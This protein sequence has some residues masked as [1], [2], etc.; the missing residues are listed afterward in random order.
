MSR[1]LKLLDGVRTAQSC[2]CVG[3]EVDGWLSLSDGGCQAMPKDA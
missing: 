1:A 3:L 2:D